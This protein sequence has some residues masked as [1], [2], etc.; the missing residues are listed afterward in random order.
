M[1][2]SLGGK[3]FSRKTTTPDAEREHTHD[4]ANTEESYPIV[5]PL[6]ER[7][8]R[9]RSGRFGGLLGTFDCAAFYIPRLCFKLTRTQRTQKKH[10]L[11]SVPL[12]AYRTK[13][14]V[15]IIT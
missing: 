14:T 15:K 7:P 5:V 12:P 10:H 11:P 8:G 4:S 6:L 13:P 1:F 2:F 3:C 9:G